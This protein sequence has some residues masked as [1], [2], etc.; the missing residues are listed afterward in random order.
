M[1]EQSEGSNPASQVRKATKS[2]K[3]EALGLA[4]FGQ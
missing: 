2:S 1:K 3:N 4:C